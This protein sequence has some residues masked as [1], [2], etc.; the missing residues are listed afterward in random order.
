MLCG[1]LPFAALS[2][3]V[4]HAAL[5]VSGDTGLAHLAVA[6][7]TP[8]VT[9]FGPVSPRL[10]GPPRGARHTAL[11]HA[12]PP[13]D[14]HGAVPDPR[15]LRIGAD[16]AVTAALAHLGPPVPAGRQEGGACVRGAAGRS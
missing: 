6:H 4:A 13:G 14:P 2:A 11:W 10:W 16:E 9:L 12:G 5:I 7:G 3:L 8:S 15:L 1:G